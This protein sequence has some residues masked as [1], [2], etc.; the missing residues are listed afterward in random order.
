MSV[1]QSKAIRARQGKMQ[2][3]IGRTQRSVDEMKK[4]MLQRMAAK[5]KEKRNG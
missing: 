2:R 1:G 3:W 4:R 5:A